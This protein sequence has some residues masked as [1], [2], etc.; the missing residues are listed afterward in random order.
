MKKFLYFIPFMGI[1][2]SI[3]QKLAQSCPTCVGR[4]YEESPPF[5]TDE[6]YECAL[7]T[8]DFT[9]TDT[10]TNSLSKKE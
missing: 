1:F 8:T 6:C 2:L 3:S 9:Q 5:F 7:N 4:V 10:N